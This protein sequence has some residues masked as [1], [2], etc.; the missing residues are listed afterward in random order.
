MW[1]YL[2]IAKLQVIE[3]PLRLAMLSIQI[4]DHFIAQHSYY[5]NM[6]RT[7]DQAFVDI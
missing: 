1:F 4:I 2:L 7:E 5:E 6:Q 3:V